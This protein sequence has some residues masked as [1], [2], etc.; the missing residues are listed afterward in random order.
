MKVRRFVA[1]F[2]THRFPV[3]IPLQLIIT[4]SRNFRNAFDAARV[5]MFKHGQMWEQSQ[6]RDARSLPHF[7]EGEFMRESCG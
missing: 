4:F 3:Y 6:R 2:V 1:V 5:K 7:F